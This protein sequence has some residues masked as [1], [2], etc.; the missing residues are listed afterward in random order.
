M[1]RVIKKFLFMEVSRC[2]HARQRQ[3]NVQKQCAA[4]AKFFF[5]LITPIVV[6]HRSPALPPPLSITLHLFQQTIN[7][8]ESFAFS[9]G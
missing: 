7:I 4:R 8:I 6:F 5:L 3:R 9:P 1:K 2:S